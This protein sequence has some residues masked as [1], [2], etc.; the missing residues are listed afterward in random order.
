VNSLFVHAGDGAATATIVTQYDYTDQQRKQT[1]GAIGATKGNLNNV[2]II[3]ASAFLSSRGGGLQFEGDPLPFCRLGSS[4]LSVSI[5]LG[6][7]VGAKV[8]ISIGV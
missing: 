8:T 3:D 1:G 4:W 6:Y 5:F 2:I 7:F